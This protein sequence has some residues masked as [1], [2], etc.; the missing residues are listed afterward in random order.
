MA[1]KSQRMFKE[2]ICVYH[3]AS[4]LDNINVPPDKVLD[5]IGDYIFRIINSKDINAAKTPF[6][7]FSCDAVG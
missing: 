7:E 6:R 4:Y 3:Y 5:L 1:R 2:P